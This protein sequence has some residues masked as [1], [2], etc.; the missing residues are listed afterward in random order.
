MITQTTLLCLHL[1]TKT[2]I[3]PVSNSYP[4][5][6]HFANGLSPYIA[7]QP[8]ITSTGCTKSLMNCTLLRNWTIVRSIVLPRAF[9][10]EIIHHWHYVPITPEG[11]PTQFSH[12]WQR[13]HPRFP[14]QKLTKVASISKLGVFAWFK[15]SSETV[16]YLTTHHSPRDL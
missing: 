10:L 13:L 6:Y 11:V 4:P 1:N 9:I 5:V 7:Y 14:P 12:R 8:A 3:N 15:R 2:I 16:C